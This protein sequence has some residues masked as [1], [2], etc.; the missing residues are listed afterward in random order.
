MR[1]KRLVVENWC[2]YRYREVEFGNTTS[3]R[4]PNGSGKTNLGN[5]VVFALTGVL[6]A[7]GV[8]EDNAHYFIA[9]GEKSYV[10]L[11]FSHEGVDCEVYRSVISAK[12]YLRVGE[13]EYA[14]D[15]DMSAA[16]SQLL[17]VEE[18]LLLDYAFVSQWEMFAFISQRDAERAAAFAQLFGTAKAEKVWR[19]LSDVKLVPADVTVD[20]QAARAA[21]AEHEAKLAEAVEAYENAKA[22]SEVLG[23]DQKA[24]KALLDAA[25]VRKVREADLADVVHKLGLVSTT[26]EQ[27]ALEVDQLV[28]EVNARRS[29][30]SAMEATRAAA[31]AARAAW[32]AYRRA[33]SGR[34]Q[35]SGE[36]TRVQAE[37]DRLKFSLSRL[38]P[39]DGY[40][41]QAERQQAAREVTALSAK[42]AVLHRFLA[43]CDPA[44]GVTAC[45]TCGTP[46]NTPDALDRFAKAKDALDELDR[47]IRAHY[48]NERWCARYDAEV[49]ALEKGIYDLQARK[50]GAKAALEAFQVVAVPE[51]PDQEAADLL[52]NYGALATSLA[53]WERRYRQQA[54]DLQTLR[55]SRDDLVARRKELDAKL[56]ELPDATE[57][58][59]RDAEAKVREYAALV[60]RLDGLQMQVRIHQTSVQLDN[61][62]LAR[63]E[64][65]TKKYWAVKRSRDRVEALR[66]LLHRDNLPARVSQY[67]LRGLQEDVNAILAEFDDPFRV[68]GVDS[69]RLVVRFS[70]GK[71]QPASRLSGGEKMMLGLAFRLA[72]NSRFAGSLGVLWLDEPTAGLNEDNRGRLHAALARFGEVSRARGLQVVLITHDPGLD[73]VCDV[74]VDLAQPAA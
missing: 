4:G 29:R 16:L 12:K 14:K 18:K 2:Q 53:D 55:A 17:G 56:A 45:P 25:A 22:A 59:L 54:A 10:R 33:E 6:R 19:C 60:G 44:R 20:G 66:D 68:S 63:Y 39:P 40:R 67:Y 48:E 61:Q 58:S 70:D 21:L 23:R 5:A 31:L 35:A 43:G 9:K 11:E 42:A 64:E 30:L 28:T 65:E 34:A 50:A 74:V 72:V 1:L 51:M 69:L 52:L 3:I 36:L 46:T 8:K 32:P 38:Q 7:D 15:K 71:T 26:C 62:L 73:N 41:A 57:E 13:D 47:R 24:L 27:V 49:A 37:E